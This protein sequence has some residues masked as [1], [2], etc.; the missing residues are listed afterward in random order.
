[1]HG[2]IEGQLGKF[3]EI[4]NRLSS[5]KQRSLLQQYNGGIVATLLGTPTQRQFCENYAKILV[6][7]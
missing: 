3:E 4:Y 2:Y 7:T 5:D 6:D 1:M